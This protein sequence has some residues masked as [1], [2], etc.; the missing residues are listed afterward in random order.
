M[1]AEL[2]TLTTLY[3]HIANDSR[4]NVWHIS[5]YAC[6]LILW[7]ENDFGSQIKITR[8]NLMAKAHFRSITTYHKCIHQL[9]E[10]GYITYSPTY[11]S[12]Q[13]T[14]ITILIPAELLQPVAL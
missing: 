10:L 5:L 12:Y 3:G 13:G 8:K 9:V 2:F 6:L 11:D 1:S 14:T 7:V 4:V